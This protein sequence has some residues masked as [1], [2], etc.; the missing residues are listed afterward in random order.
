MRNSSAGGPAYHAT[1]RSYT[2][3]P[4]GGMRDLIRDIFIY[5]VIAH[6]MAQVALKH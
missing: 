1:I 6:E 2:H 5:F 3:N 4:F